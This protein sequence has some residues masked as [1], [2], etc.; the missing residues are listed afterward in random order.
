MRVAQPLTNPR[1]HVDHRYAVKTQLGR[2]LVKVFHERRTVRH[3]QRRFVVEVRG[4]R[5]DPKK[6]ELLIQHIRDSLKRYRRLATSWGSVDDK[7]P[8]RRVPHALVL[9][10]VGL[11]DNLLEAEPFLLPHRENDRRDLCG[12]ARIYDRSQGLVTCVMKSFAI[13]T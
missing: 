7:V 4:V 2:E 10:A 6:V 13:R 11:K 3:D 5:V 1:V 12:L 8:G 9:G